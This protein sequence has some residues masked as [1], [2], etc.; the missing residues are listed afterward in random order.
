MLAVEH[1]WSVAHCGDAELERDRRLADDL[2]RAPDGARDRDGRL[3]G[4]SEIGVGISESRIPI[5]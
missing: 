1:W 3:S 4:R 2:A 5:T